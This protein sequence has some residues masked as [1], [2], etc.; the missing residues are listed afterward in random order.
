MR[1]AFDGSDII[2]K[3]IYRFTV[4]TVVLHSHFDQHTI[5][6]SLTINDLRIKRIFVAIDVSHK[7]IDSAFI[8]EFSFLFLTFSLIGKNDL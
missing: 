5:L 2:D 1:T 3:G 7:F 6:F 4:R 8:V